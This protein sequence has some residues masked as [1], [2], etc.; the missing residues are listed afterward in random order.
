MPA[1]QAYALFP[2]SIGHCGVAWSERGLTGVQLPEPN[3]ADTRARMARRFPQCSE[4][5]APPPVQEAIGAVVA[6]LG[7]RPRAPLDLS[8]VVLDMDGVPPFHQGVYA[9]AR[10]QLPGQTVTYGEIAR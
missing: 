5:V 10:R 6:L 4:A 2:S 9:L 1:T 3:E 8:N 7:G